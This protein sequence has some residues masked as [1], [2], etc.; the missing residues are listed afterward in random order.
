MLTIED[1]QALLNIIASDRLTLRG[2]EAMAMAKLQQKLALT[3]DAAR[4]PKDD[5]GAD[6]SS[7]AQ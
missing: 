3:I 1:F 2:N 6:S 5:D 4:K 7:P